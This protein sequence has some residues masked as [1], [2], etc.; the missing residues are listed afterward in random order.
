V[1]KDGINEVE[2]DEDEKDDDNDTSESP[3]SSVIPISHEIT[4]NEH[5]K[6]CVYINCSC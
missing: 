2:S 1:A 4:L 3:S 6:V 5:S